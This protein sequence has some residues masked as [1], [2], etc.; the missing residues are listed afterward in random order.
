[1]DFPGIVWWGKFLGILVVDRQNQPQKN[2]GK[3]PI[4]I[5][6]IRKIN[7]THQYQP[8]KLE[9][10]KKVNKNL[11]TTHTTIP[12]RRKKIIIIYFFFFFF[13]FSKKPEFS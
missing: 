5:I 7:K 10:N 8:K 4:K 6:E 1:V 12:R 11:F 13:E 9:I 3:N 2:P